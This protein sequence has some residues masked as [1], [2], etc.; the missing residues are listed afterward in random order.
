MRVTQNSGSSSYLRTLEDIQYSKNQTEKR[1]YTGNDLLSLSDDPK[2]LIISKQVT[3]LID[4]NKTFNNNI[5]SGLSELRATSDVI[6][7]ITGNIDTMKQLA[8]DATTTGNSTSLSSL[9]VYV[10]GLL[11]DIIGNANSE[12]SGKYLF[13]GTKTTADSINPVEDMNNRYPFELVQGDAT[14]DNPSGLKV[15]FKGNFEEK[16]INKNSTSTEVI[17][18]NAKE[19][20]GENGTE[21]FEQ[22]ISLYNTLA[23]NSDGTLRGDNTTFTQEDFNRLNIAN[24]KISQL[25]DKMYNVSARNGSRINRLGAISLQMTEENT[26]LKEYRSLQADTDVASSAIK[27]SQDETALNYALQVGSR[28]IQQTLFDFLS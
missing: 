5:E 11:N 14:E 1:L 27:L 17:N 3:T 12:F 18:T 25:Q 21:V 16:V 8:I 2:R 15:I 6:D 7:A 10:K 19:V 4:R 13:S 28:L 26:R 24:Q 20:F 9:A 23:Y 22:I